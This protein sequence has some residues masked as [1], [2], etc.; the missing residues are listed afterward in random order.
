MSPDA[1]RA[2]YERIRS[3]VGDGVTVV[4]A[5]KYVALGDMRVLVDAG[6]EVVGE[7][8][9]QDLGESTPN[10]A[11]HSAG[12]IDISSQ[13]DGGRESFYELVPPGLG[14]AAPARRRARRVNPRGRVVQS[15]IIPA[16]LPRFLQLW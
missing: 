14:S 2:N 5:T 13:Q 3:E 9:A 11:M 7:N 1:V 10:T 8:R 16:D 12:A 6:I 15:G 4:A